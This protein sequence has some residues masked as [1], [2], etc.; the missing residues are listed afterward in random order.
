VIDWGAATLVAAGGFMQAYRL[1][2]WLME[3]P[4]FRHGWDAW[5]SGEPMPFY[6]KHRKAIRGWLARDAF[7]R[8]EE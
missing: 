2:W 3:G 1:P 5:K 7:E 4:M 6:L 8:G